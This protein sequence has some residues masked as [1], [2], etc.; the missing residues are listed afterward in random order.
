MSDPDEAKPE[1]LTVNDDMDRLVLKVDSSFLADYE[2]NL[3]ITTISLYGNVY[4]D[5]VM[6]I[7]IRTQC[8]PRSTTVTTNA[9]DKTFDSYDYQSSNVAQ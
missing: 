1:E 2:I 9:K 8:G 5:E 3:M 7:H 6:N 4:T